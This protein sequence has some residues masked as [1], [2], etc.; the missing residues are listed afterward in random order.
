MF[1]GGVENMNRFEIWIADL[2]DHSQGHVQFGRRPVIIVS[3]DKSNLYSK[4]VTISHT[5]SKSQ[6][7]YSLYCI[8]HSCILHSL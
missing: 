1:C 7:V 5:Y 4:V 2:P 8:L 3:N 6:T